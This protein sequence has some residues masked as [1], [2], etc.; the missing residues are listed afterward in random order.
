MLTPPMSA[1]GTWPQAAAR[2]DSAGRGGLCLPGPHLPWATPP[3]PLPQP[4]PGPGGPRAPG[5]GHSEGLRTPPAVRGVPQA[6]WLPWQGWS[7]TECQR[8]EPLWPARPLPH[9]RTPCVG[10]RA[11]CPSSVLPNHRASSPGAL[12]HPRHA[13]P[14]APRVST[15]PA[16]PGAQRAPACRAG[17][18]GAVQAQHPAG[19]HKA[20]P[21]R[22]G[23]A[24]SIPRPGEANPRPGPGPG[25]AGGGSPRPPGAAV[26]HGEMLG[27]APPPGLPPALP[28]GVPGVPAGGCPASPR[29]RP[30]RPPRAAPSDTHRRAG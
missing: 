4:S 21:R 9:S 23:G 18:E 28:D 13:A 7:C 16:A 27:A 24:G 30:A 3:Q 29:A 8:A 22:G 25:R 10:A 11:P 5:A 20:F 15:L 2:R 6:P 1:S 17:W 19:C 12:P 26:G 14:A